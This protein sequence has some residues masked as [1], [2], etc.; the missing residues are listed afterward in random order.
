MI[1]RLAHKRYLLWLALGTSLMALVMA[2]L[3]LLQLDQQRAIRKSNDLGTDSVTALAFQLEREFLRLRP[4]LEAHVASGGQGDR[5]AMRL[6]QDLFA[7]RFQLLHD[8]PSS[9]AL[10]ERSEY[11]QTMPAIE[12]LIAR[13][14]AFLERTGTLDTEEARQLLQAFHQIAPDIQALTMAANAHMS[15]LVEKQNATMLSQNESVIRLIIGL[16]L[17]LLAAAAAL[18]WRQRAQERERAA[19]QQL[20]ARLQSAN[21]AAEAANRGKSQFLAN[22]SHELRTPFNGVLGMLTLLDTTQLQPEQAEYIKTART[23]ANH[24]L[25]LLNDILDVSALEAGKMTIHPEPV[26]TQSLFND[27][28]QLMRPLAQQKG[29]GFE[30]VISTELPAWIL[31]DGTRIKQIVLNLITNAIKFSESGQITVSADRAL[32]ASAKGIFPLRVT[33][34]D[35]GIGMDEATIQRLFQRFS[36]GDGSTLRRYGGSGLGLEISRNL[37]RLMGGDIQASS[38]LGEG[39]TFTLDLP[40]SETSAPTDTAS[41]PQQSDYRAPGE[42]GLKVLV[43]DDQPVNR[44]YLGALLQRMGHAVVFAENGQQAVAQ[45]IEQ[46]PD[47]VFMDLHMP[48]MD[49]IQATQALRALNGPL[50]SLPVIAL[51]ADAFKDTR[52]R[53]LSQGMDGFIAKPAGMEVIRDTLIQFFGRRGA[54]VVD[55]VVASDDSFATVADGKEVDT[56]PPQDNQDKPK[57]Q[58]KRRRFRPGDLERFLDMRQVGDVCLGVSVASYRDL[59]DSFY[60]DST[61]ALGGLLAALSDEPPESLKS[62]AHAFKGAAASLGFHELAQLARH[63]EQHSADLT[64]AQREQAIQDLRAAWDMSHA[65]CLRMGLTCL[66]QVPYTA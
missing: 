41:M 51:T 55:S 28:E 36:Q 42:P 43:A 7:S 10:Q 15:V 50:A 27:I 35:Q 59:A 33:V 66:E 46:Q 62:K 18:T 34:Q 8:T 19:L 26:Q 20:T 14:D 5:E 61:Q 52:D 2:V 30:M 11:T 39:S 64:Q 31:A 6:R 65:L 25:T 29:L 60:Q 45:V 9:T 44:Q 3:L 4:L 17:L 12:A 22:M 47:M 40:L 32:G 1:H 56:V 63:V 53:V 37:A 48:L 23:S 54:P 24:L 57:A 38:V 49:G 21:L 13:T 16:M 58:S